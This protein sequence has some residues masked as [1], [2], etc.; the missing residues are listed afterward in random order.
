[1]R[2]INTQEKGMETS[3]K[4]M[5]VVYVKEIT[6]AWTKMI[7]SWRGEMQVGN[8]SFHF[9]VKPIGIF[10]VLNTGVRKQELQKMIPKFWFWAVIV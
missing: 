10:A 5:A 1:M 6:E 3:K 2:T 8:W 9:K 4:E 7:T